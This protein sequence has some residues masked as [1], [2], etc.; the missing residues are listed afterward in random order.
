MQK[1]VEDTFAN[2]N[3]FRFHPIVLR[4]KMLKEPFAKKL[5]LRLAPTGRRAPQAVRTNAIRSKRFQRPIRVVQRV[6]F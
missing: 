2:L 6:T 1:Q 4:L 5:H 3:A